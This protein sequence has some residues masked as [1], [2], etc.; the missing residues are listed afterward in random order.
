MEKARGQVVSRRSWAFTLVG[1]MREGCEQ[2]A[3]Q[4]EEEARMP[5]RRHEVPQSHMRLCRY[6][7]GTGF[8]N[9]GG[10]AGCA[11]GLEEVGSEGREERRALDSPACL[12]L[13]TWA[14]QAGG[15]VGPSPLLQGPH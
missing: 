14:G 6:R 10:A 1:T 11:A 7:E 2:E 9:D 4:G 13:C 5:G 15:C 3:W 8:K 12:Q